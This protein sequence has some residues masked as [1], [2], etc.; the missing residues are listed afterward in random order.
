[1]RFMVCLSLCLSEIQVVAEKSID[2]IQKAM[3]LS[4]SVQYMLHYIRLLH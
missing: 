2:Y 4:L 1:M 3:Y